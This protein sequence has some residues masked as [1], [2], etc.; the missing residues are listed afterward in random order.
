MFKSPFFMFILRA[1]MPVSFESKNA[2]VIE[3]KNA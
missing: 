2:Y 1:K 3:G